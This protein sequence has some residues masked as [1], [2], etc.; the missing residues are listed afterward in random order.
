[1]ASNSN[2]GPSDD[3]LAIREAGTSGPNYDISNADVL[4]E[5]ARWKSFCSFDVLS[6]QGD[7]AEIRFNSLPADMDTFAQELYAFC[8]DLVDQGTGCLH[9]FI[10]AAEEMGEEIP[11]DMQK[12][13]EGVDFEDEGYGVEILKRE[14]TNRK[15]VTLW[16]D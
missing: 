16:W 10:E 14:V 8:P 7:R 12:L 3:L 6:A 13:I 11:P 9:E 4:K 1:M 5:L 2:A 15:S